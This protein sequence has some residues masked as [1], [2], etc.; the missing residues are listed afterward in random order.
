MK[1]PKAHL[2]F[3]KCRAIVKKHAPRLMKL[4]S[5]NPKTVIIKVKEYSYMPRKY[6]SRD[7]YNQSGITIRFKTEIDRIYIFPQQCNSYK[8]VLG[9]LIHELIHL[10]IGPLIDLIPKKYFKKEMYLEE[11]AVISLE[12]LIMKLS[13]LSPK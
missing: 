1:E 7:L 6:W 12:K 9:T 2:N 10:R 3:L 5:I 13:K 11:S 8:D 4:L